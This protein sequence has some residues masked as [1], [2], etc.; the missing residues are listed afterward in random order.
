VASGDELSRIGDEGIKNPV[1][2]AGYREPS[3]SV[4]AVDLRATEGF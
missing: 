1:A 4:V 3:A 2:S